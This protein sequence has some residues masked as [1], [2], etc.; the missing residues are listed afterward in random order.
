MHNIIEINK[1]VAR[2]P[3]F[4]LKEPADVVIPADTSLAIVGLNAS[5]KTLLGDMLTGAHPLLGNEIK[6]DFSPSASNKA[7][8]NGHC[9][10]Q[11]ANAIYL[12]E[13][14]GFCTRY[15]LVCHGKSAHY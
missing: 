8:Q 9:T 5:G 4:R 12:W 14:K 10:N 7:S 1:A 6:Y 3:E 11:S 13:F 2:M 15:R